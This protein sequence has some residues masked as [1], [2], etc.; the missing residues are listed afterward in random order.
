MASER[1]E[2]E[3]MREIEHIVREY[4]QRSAGAG[5]SGSAPGQ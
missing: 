5:P 3:K 2:P 4:E 1:S